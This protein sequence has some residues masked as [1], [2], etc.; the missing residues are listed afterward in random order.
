ML[1]LNATPA[2]TEVLKSLVLP[3]CGAFT[4]VDN[5]KLSGG[6]AGNNFFV[7]PGKN[8]NN[9]AKSVLIP[10]TR[11]STLQQRNKWYYVQCMYFFAF[12]MHISGK[13]P[14]AS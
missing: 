8:N 9:T 3:G 5:N 7:E 10:S 13:N 14:C 2:G 11:I 4:I 6:D 1:L 12:K